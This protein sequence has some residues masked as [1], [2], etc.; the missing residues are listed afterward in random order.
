MCFTTGRGAVFGCRPVPSI[1]LS[2]NTALFRRMTGDI[3]LDCGGIIEGRESVQSAG[4]RI[5]EQ[6]L[7]TASGQRTCS[8]SL[9]FGADEFVPWQLGAVL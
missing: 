2:T 1:K 7:A 9:G 8:E 4:K 5:F 3:D 6:I